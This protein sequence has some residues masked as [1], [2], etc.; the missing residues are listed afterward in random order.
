MNDF[1]VVS[2]LPMLLAALAVLIVLLIILNKTLGQRRRARDCDQGAALFR[3][4][5]AT[6]TCGRHGG[7]GRHSSRCAQARLARVQV[8]L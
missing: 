6:G 8:S 4:E 5:D 3:S 7:R 1:D 2:I